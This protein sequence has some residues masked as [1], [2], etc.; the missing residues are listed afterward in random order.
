MNIICLK[1]NLNPESVDIVVEMMIVVR[2]GKSVDEIIE[3]DHKK[4]IGSSIHGNTG[5]KKKNFYVKL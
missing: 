1:K 5:L 3:N 4:E 2:R